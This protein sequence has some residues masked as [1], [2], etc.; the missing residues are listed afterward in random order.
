MT[1]DFHAV[2]KSH[3]Q[4]SKAVKF[5]FVENTFLLLILT[6]CAN[7]DISHVNQDNTSHQHAP[8]SHTQY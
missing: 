5:A 6:K 2:T 1:A 7:C 3:D 8:E 4:R